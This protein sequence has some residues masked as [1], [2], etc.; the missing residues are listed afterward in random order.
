MICGISGLMERIRQASPESPISVWSEGGTRYYS[1]FAN[2]AR[3]VRD[4]RLDNY[5]GTFHQ[6]D[7]LV[8]VELT[9]LSFRSKR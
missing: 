1:A 6:Q 9:L 3:S 7:D 2:T 4:R 8:S 5:I